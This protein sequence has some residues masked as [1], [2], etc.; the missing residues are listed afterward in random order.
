MEAPRGERADRKVRAGLTAEGWCASR[1]SIPLGQDSSWGRGDREGKQN[2][3][4]KRAARTMEA[5]LKTK[6]AKRLARRRGPKPRPVA[7]QYAEGMTDAQK[8]FHARQAAEH[9]AMKR[10][11]SDLFHFWRDCASRACRRAR[12][13]SGDAVAC[14]EQ[15]WETLPEAEKIWY[16]VAIKTLAGGATPREAF[17][18]GVEAALDYARR[19][20]G[21]RAGAP[22]G[23]GSA[24]ART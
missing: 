16:R 17:A 23:S 11:Q 8:R 24:S 4:A 5:A 15:R 13:C 19:E 18:A 21:D 10:W 6:L 9:A 3:G 22:P 7:V 1:R 20:A 2:S 14:M 12:A